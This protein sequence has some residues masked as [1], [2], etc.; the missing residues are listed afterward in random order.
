[1]GSSKKAT[2]GYRYYMGLHFGICHGPVDALQ[3]VVVGERSAWAGNQSSSGSLNIAQAELFGGDEREGGVS[4]Q[5]DV[6]MG[7]AT[8][9]T[10]DYLVSKLGA[11]IPAF[12]GI[13]S[14]VWRG[15]QVS[16]NN[17]YVKPWAFRVKRILQGWSSG[18]AWYPEKA[19]I[20]GDAAPCSATVVDTFDIDLGIDHAGGSYTVGIPIAGLA[21]TDVVTIWRPD[22]DMTY[23]AM[24]GWNE[25]HTDPLPYTHHFSVNNG[26]SNT[27][28]WG[29]WFATASAALADAKARPPVVLTGHSSYTIWHQ[30]DNLLDNAYGLSLRVQITSSAV[31]SGMNPAHIIYQCLTDT[32]WGLGY[33]PASIDNTSFTAAADALFSENFGLSLLWNQQDTV[34]SFIGMVIDHIGG[35]LYVRPDTGQFALK[36]IRADYV[37]D[38]LPQYGPNNLISAEDYQRQAWGETVNEITVVYTGACSGNEQP[39]TVQDAANIITQGGVVAQTRQY[40]GITSASLAQRVALRD[41]NAASTPL[42]KIRLTATRA[43]WAVFPGD[44]FR[45]TWPEYGI[46]D[47]VYR[48]L[49]VNLGTL[50]DGRIII[51][52][53]EDVFGLPDNTYLVDQPSAWE[54]PTSEPAPAPYRA[55]LE[56]PYWDLVRNLSAADMAYVDN[57]S[58]YLE[59]LAVRPGNAAINYSISARTGSADYTRRGNGDFCP[60]ATIVGAMGKTTTA[61][62]LANSIDLDLVEAGGY[63]VI[64]GEYVLVSS[65]NATAGTA[66]LSRGVLDTVPVDHATGARIWFADGWQGFDTTEAADGET[67]DV[68]LLPATSRGSLPIGSAPVDSLTFDQRQYRPY[69]PGKLQINATIYPEWIDG[70]AAM[71]LTWAHRDRLLQTAYIVEQ[72]EASIGPEAGTTYNLRIYGETNSLIRTYSGLSGT[73]QTYAT[74]TEEADSLIPVLNAP[75]AITWTPQTSGFGTAP[76]Y[77][78]AYDG[79]GLIIAIG[80]STSPLLYSSPDGVTWTSRTSNLY[81]SAQCTGVAHDGS[82]TWVAIGASSSGNINLSSSTNGTTWT[83]RTSG[84]SVALRCV[85]FGGGRWVAAGDSGNL[86]GST[87]GTSWAHYTSSFSTTRIWG[88]AYGG[89]LW[90]AVGETGKLATSSN[91]TTWTQQTSSFG[92]TLIRCIA[93]GAGLWIAGGAGGTL[94]TSTN[95][96]TWTQISGGFGTAQIESI[97]YDATIGAFVL[98]TAD[99]KFAA[100]FDGFAWVDYGSG[101]G[102]VAVYAVKRCGSILVEAGNSGK[103]STSPGLVS[104]A[105]RLNGRLRVELE[106][107]RGGLVSYQKHNHTVLREGY[108][109][110][111][112]YYYGGQ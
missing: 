12:R 36:L 5:L 33:P 35:M 23:V 27:L 68:K 69:A 59:T 91:G 104:S 54:D 75:Y 25:G 86:I 88:V 109:F 95:G 15:G 26:V 93:Y 89:G 7:G 80:G 92:T 46:D 48:A 107:V 43:A 51:D 60:S 56:A 10:N 83:A 70:I 77:A 84:V 52:A 64:D 112:G 41:L 1:M 39:M 101:F 13:L 111:Y 103:L 18:G 53:V 37:R 82:S 16:S 96:T 108:G 22:E 9:T 97:A 105:Y 50:T 61:V 90:V 94:A 49:S 62:T 2:V 98:G 19:E 44:V 87:D 67:V 17:P 81:A 45:L 11:V 55:L 30:D 42:A 21:P 31:P 20:A 47:V 78:L 66:T 4:G 99:G 29:D 110:N 79:S 73:S 76:I 24:R 106:A 100:S 74:A 32:A 8:Q 28:Y 71:A 58:G 34:E 38:T 40:P 102:G 57:L 72:S 85:G 63:A 65:I 3:Q 6:L 14:A